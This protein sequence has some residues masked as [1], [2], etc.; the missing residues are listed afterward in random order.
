MSTNI[1]RH[2]VIICKKEIA[3]YDKH[4]IYFDFILI[5]NILHKR[6][7][8]YKYIVPHIVIKNIANYDKYLIYI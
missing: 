2:I 6:R 5:S 7:N 3:N 4:F 1:D 8:K